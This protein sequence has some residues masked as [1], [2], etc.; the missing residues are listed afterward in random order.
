MLPLPNNLPL[1]KTY[2]A[3][4][5]RASDVSSECLNAR[6]FKLYH[7]V[8][9]AVCADRRRR[10]MRISR[11]VE[12]V[13]KWTK[14]QSILRR[15]SACLNRLFLADRRNN[16]PFLTSAILL[17][18]YNSRRSHE[19]EPRRQLGTTTGFLFAPRSDRSECVSGGFRKS[20]P[21]LAV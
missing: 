14:H 20:V 15:G 8:F 1:Y 7:A 3:F 12:L 21:A 10:T 13:F 6:V 18:F 16:A 19:P 9:R 2:H 17:I 11:Q 4:A 5:F